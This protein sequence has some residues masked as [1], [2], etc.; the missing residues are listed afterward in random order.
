MSLVFLIS[1]KLKRLDV[2]D[3]AWGLAFIVVALVSFGLGNQ[4][5]GINVASLVNLLVVIWGLRLFSHIVRRLRSHG[6]DPRY[7]EV[8]KNWHGNQVLNAYF[9]VFCLQAVLAWVIALPVILVNRVGQQDLGGWALA[10]GLIWLIGLAF[11]AIGDEQLKNFIS[12]SRNKGKIMDQGL[13]RYS[14]HPNYF[15]ELAQWWG[16]FIITLS[17]PLGWIG[18]AGP[19]I[20]TLLIL[21]VSGIPLNEKRQ[22]KKAGW[23]DYQRRTSVLIPLQLKK[24]DL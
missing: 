15:G 8:R 4:Y 14:R 18:F 5:L 6:E 22:A 16:I 13:W 2:V 23:K 20:L 17:V 9:K 7:S 19:L 21:F 1:Q 11:E 3:A 24:I 12:D 10:G